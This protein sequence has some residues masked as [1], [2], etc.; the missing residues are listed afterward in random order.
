LV[1]ACRSPY[2]IASPLVAVPTKTGP[3]KSTHKSRH[4]P[5]KNLLQRTSLPQKHTQSIIS[6]NS[7]KINHGKQFFFPFPVVYLPGA[8]MQRIARTP[9]FGAGRRDEVL[10]IWKAE[11]MATPRFVFA[12]ADAVQRTII[13][14]TFILSCATSW[15]LQYQH[16]TFAHTS[17]TPS[18]RIFSAKPATEPLYLFSSFVVFERE[19]KGNGIL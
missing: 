11:L 5:N 12:D 3:S 7:P 10:L 18:P 14:N 17:I 16:I 15:L 6:T 8:Y 2:S 9:Y 1:E 4:G 19:F 13:T